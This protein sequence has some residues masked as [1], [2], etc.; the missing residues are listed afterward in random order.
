MRGVIT[1][2]LVLNYCQVH[3]LLDLHYFVT[4]CDVIPEDDNFLALIAQATQGQLKDT[5][6]TI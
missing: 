3:E 4:R 5:F 2:I 1:I 6:V